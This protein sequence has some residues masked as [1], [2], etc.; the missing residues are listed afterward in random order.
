[1]PCNTFTNVKTSNDCLTDIKKLSA[2]AGFLVCETKLKAHS[3]ATPASS[4]PVTVSEEL[5]DSTRPIRTG[6]VCVM[7]D[8]RSFRRPL[9]LGC[10]GSTIRTC[11]SLVKSFCHQK[12]SM[13]SNK[14][15]RYRKEIK[16]FRFLLFLLHNN[17]D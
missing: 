14:K 6:A 4:R 15:L 5:T 12:N 9:V 3:K 2:A 7:N 10:A 13:G 17:T 8:S 1:M 16:N 11:K